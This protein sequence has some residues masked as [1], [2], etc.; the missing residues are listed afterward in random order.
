MVMEKWKK[1]RG[2]ERRGSRGKFLSSFFLVLLI[3]LSFTVNI[4]P[5]SEAPT[6]HAES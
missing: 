3:S 2:E 5:V 1:A 6:N 4:E